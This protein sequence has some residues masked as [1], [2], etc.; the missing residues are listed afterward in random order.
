MTMLR[1]AIGLA[2][3]AGQGFKA[4]SAPSAAQHKA[5]GQGGSR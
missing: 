5:D 4:R 2:I 1:V 3:A